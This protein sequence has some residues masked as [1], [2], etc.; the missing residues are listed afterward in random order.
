MY[1]PTH[2]EA[3]QS[4]RFRCRGVGRSRGRPKGRGGDLKEDAAPAVFAEVVVDDVLAK[5]V[6]AQVGLAV[7]ALQL[8]AVLGGVD[9]K[10]AVAL[11]DGAVAADGGVLLQGRRDGEGVANLAAVAVGVV[12]G[13]LARGRR[14]GRTWG[15]GHRDGGGVCGDWGDDG[16]VGKV[17][18]VRAVIAK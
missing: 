17:D 8:D 11:A 18:A 10:V 4:G 12:V 1:I 15:R 14:E 13:E 2:V 3:H 5:V 9:A 6:G 7:I 16:W